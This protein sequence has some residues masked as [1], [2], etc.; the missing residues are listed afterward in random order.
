MKNIFF[1]LTILIL[2]FSCSAISIA[3]DQ[4]YVHPDINKNALI[5]SNIDTFLKNQLGIIK[6][7]EAVLK[8]KTLTEWMKDGGSLEDETVCRSKFHFHDPTKTWDSA[9]LTNVAI[10]TFC[11]DYRHR[12]SLVWAQDADN[13]WTWQKAR[14][15]YFEALTNTNKDIREQKMANTFRSL[16][17]VIHL[18]TDSSVP[19]HARND[20]HIFPFLVPGI[21]VEIGDPTFESWT[22]NNIYNLNY[23]GVIIDQSI[24]SE[25][26]ANSSAPIAISAL[27]DQDKYNGSNPTVTTG[28]SIGLTEYSNANFFS[29]DT[30][31]TAFS[32]P[33]WSSVEEYE[34][35]I[36]TTTGEV[37]TYLRKTNDGELIEH[38]AAGK[39][40]YKYL[41]SG[42]KRLGLKLD[43]KVYSDY[44]SK[45]IPLAVGY[46]AGL[47]NY[48]FRG[49]IE[50]T[51]P[52]SGV[53]AFTDN[54]VQVLPSITLL[55]QNT[56]SYGEDMNDGSIELLIRYKLAQADPFQSGLVLVDDEFTYLVVPEA[57][58]I[59]SIPRN[60]PVE[61]T[62]NLNPA[63][64]LYAT[65]VYLHAVYNG[66]LG[67]ED[68]A[69]AVRVKDISEPTPIDLFNNMDRICLNNNWYVAGSP[70][71]IAVVDINHDG[72]AYGANEWDVY[73][74]DLQDI[75]IKLSPTN[76]AQ[77]ASPTVYNYH[78]PYLLA[79]NFLR[80]SYMLTDYQFKYNFYVFRI[81]QDTNDWW[82]HALVQQTCFPDLQ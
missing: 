52:D 35:I 75:Y 3:Y 43:E 25:A 62:F 22:K 16:G 29:E 31:F 39:W 80:T 11:L 61:L 50:I 54:P 23:N 8:S 44:A 14:Q 26:V 77:Y 41:P 18:L 1:F 58:G 45:L 7:I 59:R 21:G 55:A 81:P 70:E 20:I 68:G 78:V 56:T 13:L 76:N 72:R 53:Y 63:L 60:N 71:A 47:L 69:V 24:F 65:N 2:S 4:D 64:P 28:S 38:L 67:N 33:A 19:A 32:Y 17:Q 51:L 46:S 49:D 73:A 10:D 36:D 37:R 66:V 82:G 5:Q 6:G 40:F 48:F 79:S 12:S 57:N 15:Y 27:W 30:I 34:E 42:L 74:H 9:G